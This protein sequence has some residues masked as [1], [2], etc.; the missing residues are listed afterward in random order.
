MEEDT[1]ETAEIKRVHA[2]LKQQEK[3]RMKASIAKMQARAAEAIAAEATTAAATPSNNAANANSASPS[4]ASSMS[5]G[6]SGGGGPSTTDEPPSNKA[7]VDVEEAVKDT[8]RPIARHPPS[9]PAEMKGLFTA[10]VE[11]DEI[12]QAERLTISPDDGKLVFVLDTSDDGKLTIEFDD[13]DD[14]ANSAASTL[15]DTYTYATT[16]LFVKIWIAVSCWF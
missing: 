1:P 11:N 3:A 14:A 4:S 12:V 15:I 6:A 13:L 16:S 5:Q 9:L 10:D 2:E 7:R 8:H